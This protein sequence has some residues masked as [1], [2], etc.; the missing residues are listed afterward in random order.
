M[1]NVI[2]VSAPDPTTET[3]ATLSAPTTTSPGKAGPPV[4]ATPSQTV[5]QAL[6]AVFTPP[7]QCRDRYYVESKPNGY[8]T[9]RGIFSDTGDRLY[10]ACQPDL[11]AYGNYYSPGACPFGMDIAA[12]SS[13]TSNGTA[14]TTYTDICCQRHVF[15]HLFAADEPP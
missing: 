6:T 1:V 9:E 7:A 15:R 3:H 10:R 8:Y 11:Q 2:P 13:S 12:V 4:Q 5:T 14:D